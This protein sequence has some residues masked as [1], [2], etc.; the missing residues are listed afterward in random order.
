MHIA[1]KAHTFFRDINWEKIKD[2]SVTS[3]LYEK[4]QQ[5]Y[6]SIIGEGNEIAGIY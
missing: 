3:P 5:F 2:G 4:A 1:I 6:N